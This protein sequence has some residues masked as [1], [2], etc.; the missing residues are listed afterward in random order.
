MSEAAVGT[1]AREVF[2]LD[3]LRR[4]V[5]PT[6]V[7]MSDRVWRYNAAGVVPRCVVRP[8]TVEAVAAVVR[9]VGRQGGALVP[10]GNA[11]HLGIGFPPR[12][13]DVALCTSQL[14]RI[15][16]HDADDLTTTV[17]AGVTL[18]DLNTRL[19]EAGQWLPFDPP[20]GRDVTIGGLIAADR[21][22]PLRLAHGKVRDF[23]IGLR[24]VMADGAIVRGG[25]KVVKN[26]A[27][28]DLPKLFVGSFGT[29]GVIVEAT[30]KV[31][32]RPREMRLYVVPARSVAEATQ[33]ALGT[34]RGRLVPVL[35]EAVN[36]LA[37]ETIGLPTGAALVV[38]SAGSEAHVA[39]QE[40]FLRDETGDRLTRCDA[41][42]MESLLSA[43]R[44]FPQPA[45]EEVLVVRLSV[46][47]A[48]LPTLLQRI[49]AE[50]VARRISPE[51]TA[52]AGNGVA[53]LQLSAD[54]D[55]HS[56][57]LFAEWIRLH[58][59]Q[60]GGWLVFETLPRRLRGQVDPWG[61]Y[62]PTLPLMAAI[63]QKLDPQRILSPGRF[64]GG[65]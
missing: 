22:G 55:L 47:P 17:E 59:R 61:F 2:D 53:W 5:A 35:L 45:D 65:V 58:A 7:E 26:V 62:G 29:L 46:R 3:S 38:A 44:D 8:G 51:I 25:G 12:R 60:S 33:M 16:S 41:N 64:V 9:A 54:V 11:T 10:A 63:K 15:V 40:S 57:A 13:Y 14:T 27:G 4:E 20:R 32:P 39:A 31:R 19:Q 52:H 48:E 21:N 42:E 50:A 30:F 56:V 1:A 34:S 36:E 37:A 49:E 28:Y 18:H 24:V 43:L 23:L 6:P